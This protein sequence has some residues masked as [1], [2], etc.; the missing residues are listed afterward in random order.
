MFKEN[1][2][3]PPPPCLFERKPRSKRKSKSFWGGD[4][5]KIREKKPVYY[6]LFFQKNKS[7]Q[8]VCASDGF[9]F[10]KWKLHRLRWISLISTL[11]CIRVTDPG[12]FSG[13]FPSEFD[14]MEGA[15]AHFWT[16]QVAFVNHEWRWLVGSLS[17]E[18]NDQLST[19]GWFAEARI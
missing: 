1:E 15:Q 17:F 3:P 4:A 8:A 16:T 11:M 14:G 10:V 19:L 6:L 7:I 2:I 18:T 13:W 5:Q 9:S 12:C